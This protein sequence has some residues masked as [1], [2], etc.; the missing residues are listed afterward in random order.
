MKALTEATIEPQSACRPA[1]YPDERARP[2]ACIDLDRFCTGCGYNLRTLPVHCDARTGIP[3]V[4][5]TE[6]GQYQP[7]NDASTAL[8]PWLHRVTSVMLVVWMLFVAAVFFHLAL[9]EGALTYATL[10]ELTMPSGYTKRQTNI[11]GTTYSW[12]SG[13]GPLEVKAK[14]EIPYYNLFIT[15]MLLLSFATAFAGGMFAVVVFPHWPRAAY[16]ALVL[17]MPMVVGGIVVLVW[18]ADAPHLLTWGLSH[19]AAHGTAQVLGGLAGI[20]LG[21]P[22]ARLTVR[23]VLPPSVRPRL[24]YLWLADKKPCPDLKKSAAWHC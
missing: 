23:I 12:T 17:A 8:R 1:T 3:V 19:M 5:C 16:A 2:V 9:G 20:T 10:D 6:C 11:A 13:S 24:A 14:E 18:R 15:G 7:A 22:L 21:R 4:H